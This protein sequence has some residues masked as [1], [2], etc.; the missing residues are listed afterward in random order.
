[1]P[2]SYQLV[3]DCKSP[4]LLANFWAAALRYVIEPPPAGFD[5]W[6]DFYRS[7]GVPEDE[8]GGGADSINDPNGEGPRIWFQ[9]VDETKSIK[10]RIH[11][12]VNASGGRGSS[13][14]VRRERVEAEAKRLEELGATRLRTLAEPG[15]DH[16]AVGM[17]DP[18]GNE[19]DIN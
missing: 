10:N 19:F 12:D 13:L 16:Y 1:M 14:E 3:I 7:I 9:V 15:L 4:D 17:A 18:E 11:I 2:V 8:L 5:T 6:D